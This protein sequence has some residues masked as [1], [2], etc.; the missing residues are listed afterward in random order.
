MSNDLGINIPDDPHE[1]EHTTECD[2]RECTDRQCE[3]CTAWRSAC[4]IAEVPAT[5]HGGRI[6]EISG[7]VT[8]WMAEL[9][10]RCRG[11][12]CKECST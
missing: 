12:E 4:H 5:L 8:H 9:C 7:L 3:K 11:I 6:G 10:H 2:R 1:S